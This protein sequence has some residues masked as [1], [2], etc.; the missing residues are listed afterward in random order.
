MNRV[1]DK[2]RQVSRVYDNAF[3][4]YYDQNSARNFQQRSTQAYEQSMNNQGWNNYEEYNRPSNQYDY[5]QNDYSYNQN[6]N[7]NYQ[8][9][10]YF[11]Y[12]QESYYTN[13]SN[14]YVRS[15]PTRYQETTYAPTNEQPKKKSKI[16]VKAKILIGVY[17]FIVAVIAT[18]LI[19]NMATAGTTKVSASVDENITY[20]AEAVEWA[21]DSQGNV[22][23]MPPMENV[24]NFNIET[25]SNW[26][27]N[28]CDRISKIF[29]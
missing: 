26:F 20:N 27:D 4:T 22:V 29:G 15:N 9:G 7:Q 10:Q 8:G 25:K 5:Y 6:Y 19:I 28:M 24:T 1:L 16:N 14:G 21:V 12:P 18:L 11:D 17:F 13:N 3:D 23:A 2:E